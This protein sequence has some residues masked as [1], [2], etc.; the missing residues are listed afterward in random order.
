MQLDESKDPVKVKK[1]SSWQS[2]ED[3]LFGH[4]Q[5]AVAARLLPPRHPK[6]A[7][8]RRNG[9]KSLV[10]TIADKSWV[11]QAEVDNVDNH[12]VSFVPSVF[13]LICSCY[14]IVSILLFMICTLRLLLKPVRHRLV[15]MKGSCCEL[16][17]DD[18]EVNWGAGESVRRYHLLTRSIPT[19]PWV[20]TYVCLSR[21][22][23]ILI[24]L[25]RAKVSSHGGSSRL[26]RVL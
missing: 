6:N 19:A 15:T 9:K 7:A 3:S 22:T 10:D 26:H 23:S 4:T 17:V 20:I 24:S 16:Y 1:A 11:S 21:F 2:W 5:A 12:K 8:A 14:C 18:V 13:N 25:L